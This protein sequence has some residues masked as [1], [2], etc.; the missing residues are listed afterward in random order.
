M[1]Q[2]PISPL[3]PE[4]QR[5]LAIGL[6]SLM[7]GQVR[8]YNAHRGAAGTS[9]TTE[10]ARELMESMVYTLES[11]GG[12]APGADIEALLTKG[13]AV[14]E[15]KRDR[16]RHFLRLAEA[17]APEFQ[18]RYYG[19]ALR[20]LD[21][22]LQTYD[23]LHMAHRSPEG[24]D[25]PLLLPV[26]EPLR[27]IDRALYDLGC[28]W[29]ENEIL[30]RFSP[31]ALAEL[32]DA[33]PPDYWFPPQNQCEQALWNAMGKAL[34][35]RRPEP[36]LLTAG[37]PNALLCLLQGKD[38]ELLRAL[39]SDALAQVCSALDLA[40]HTARYAAGAI[41]GLLPRLIAALPGGNVSPFFW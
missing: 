37:E 30:H 31:D 20:L 36:L 38:R 9:V 34:L 16:A 21:R 26:P 23:H 10:T 41:D 4:D 40:E 12:L 11:A 18:T 28:L 39:F 35:G 5:K 1:S 25:Y 6:Y 33:A 17:S 8:S 13:Q 32:I 14:L 3:T 15:E 2:L 19:E 24:L 7:D 29:T 22:Y 27:G